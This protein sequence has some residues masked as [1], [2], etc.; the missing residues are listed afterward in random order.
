MWYYKCTR[1]LTLVALLST[2][3]QQRSSISA[4]SIFGSDAD[5]DSQD[6]SNGPEESSKQRRALQESYTTEMHFSFS[7]QNSSYDTK[8]GF[9]ML[10]L[11]GG[12][13]EIKVYGTIDSMKNTDAEVIAII[14]NDNQT[15]QFWSTSCTSY[16]WDNTTDSTYDFYHP[17][18]CGTPA[19]LSRDLGAIYRNVTDTFYGYW[20]KN[21]SGLIF[22]NEYLGNFEVSE[23]ESPFTIFFVSEDPDDYIE[24]NANVS[25][26]YSFDHYND[27][28]D[29][30]YSDNFYVFIN[31]CMYTEVNNVPGRIRTYWHHGSIDFV[32]LSLSHYN[33]S[34]L[35]YSSEIQNITFVAGGEELAA[36]FYMNCSYGYF[37][38]TSWEYK[39]YWNFSNPS[40]DIS[41]VSHTMGVINP[42]KPH[43]YLSGDTIPDSTNIQSTNVF[44][45]FHE[46]ALH[47]PDQYFSTCFELMG[48][49]ESDM[50][51]M[52]DVDFYYQDY[53]YH[54]NKTEGWSM[55]NHY[56]QTSLH[57]NDTSTAQPIV[58]YSLGDFDTYEN[59]NS[60]HLHLSKS[61]PN[62]TYD[63][64]IADWDF[65]FEMLN[66]GCLSFI[67]EYRNETSVYKDTLDYNS[68]DGKCSWDYILNG[69][70]YTD[71]FGN[72]E[73]AYEKLFGSYDY[74]G[75]DY[76]QVNFLNGGFIIIAPSSSGS[77]E[78]MDFDSSDLLIGS[79]TFIDNENDYD[80]HFDLEFYPMDY[81]HEDLNAL[82]VGGKE[83]IK[84]TSLVETYVSY[85]FIDKTLEKEQW[86]AS[87]FADQKT[88]ENPRLFSIRVYNVESQSSTNVTG[89]ECV[90]F[91]IFA[92]G[93]VFIGQEGEKSGYV[94]EPTSEPIISTNDLC[95]DSYDWE[96]GG[97]TNVFLETTELREEMDVQVGQIYL[98]SNSE[99]QLKVTYEIL[100]WYEKNDNAY[101]WDGS[102]TQCF[103]AE[104]EITY[105][106][107]KGRIKKPMKQVQLGDEALAMDTH[108]KVIFSPIKEIPHSENTI[109]TDFLLLTVTL[110]QITNITAGMDFKNTITGSRT[111]RLTAGHL[112]PASSEKL[113]AN[114]D[115]IATASYGLKMASEVQVGDCLLIV[116]AENADNDM[117]VLPATVSTISKEKG[118]GIY[119]AATDESYI[120]VNGIV[121]SP[122]ALDAASMSEV[123]KFIMN[124][125]QPLKIW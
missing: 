17:N 76:A 2:L 86:I 81:V 21:S 119:S 7:G 58:F 18:Y 83:Y 32:S 82:I 45:W 46:E 63:I 68:I 1:F 111:L 39:E 72:G 104:E 11:S 4:W 125:K 25:T 22:N 106:A 88:K 27:D 74:D 99:S 55:I 13:D 26:Q 101:I 114:Y 42:T 123:S 84:N 97:K 109:E 77:S 80:N 121:A 120:I 122:Y 65:Y 12:A 51:K 96:N 110:P 62:K 52:T 41:K 92:P 28:T 57:Y 124:R 91:H 112:L 115:T 85:E 47:E 108:G 59:Y 43:I 3:S 60:L 16:F 35:S 31:D 5:K 14:M 19:E 107:G 98:A 93:T 103:G 48:T 113:C 73:T 66:Q 30:E 67:I 50:N 15:S 118:V 105:R 87:Y 116:Q 23:W 38:E 24:I 75:H 71:E 56:W 117:K 94:T 40:C 36:L 49:V 100:W 34:E 70:I 89:K 33:T 44:L 95:T 53:Y 9:A 8:L 78:V 20:D 64:I 29:S 79:V 61:D 90:Q 69:S 10:Y 6:F 37:N 102:L 54:E